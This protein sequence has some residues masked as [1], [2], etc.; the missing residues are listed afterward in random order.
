MVEK[1]EE[2]DLWSWMISWIELAWK[3]SGFQFTESGRGYKDRQLR[4]DIGLI[5]GQGEFRVLKMLAR[6]EVKELVEC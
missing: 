3:K 1:G 6:S 5:N 4:Q 2:I